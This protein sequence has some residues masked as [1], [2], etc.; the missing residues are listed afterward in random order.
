MMINDFAILSK[1]KNTGVCKKCLYDRLLPYLL[2]PLLYSRI[3]TVSVSQ[4][5]KVS[6]KASGVCMKLRGHLGSSTGVLAASV[7][8]VDCDG[9][10]C[11]D[12][13]VVTFFRRTPLVGFNKY[14]PPTLASP[15]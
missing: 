1:R 2:E 6:T 13:T 10:D 8:S 7:D 15:C 5:W 9:D 11:D 14:V 3:L 4:D 12:G